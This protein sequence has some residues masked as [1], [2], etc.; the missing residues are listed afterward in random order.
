MSNGWTPEEEKKLIRKVDM[1]MVPILFVCATLSGLDKTAISGAAIYGLRQ[2]LGLSGSQY[3]W[4]GSAPFF[5]GLLFMG[6]AA[7]G[8]QY[9]PAIKFFAFNVLMWGVTAMCMAACTNFAGLFICRFL[10]GG[11]EALLIPAITLV[12]TM[13]YKPEE[14]PKRNAIILNV[15][16]PI[17]NGFISWTV[18]YHKGAFAGWKIIFLALGVFTFLWAFVVFFFLPN[19]PL[20]ATWLTGREKFIIIQR[21]AA[22]NTGVESKVFKKEQ[23]W[24][25][26]TDPKTWLIWF[27]IVALQVP[28]G[29]LTTFNTLIISGLGFDSLHTSL[30]AMP[31][32]AMSTLS[33]IGL[34]FL[35]ATTRKYRIALVTTSILLPLLGA[36]LCYAL[37]RD[38][39]A[40]QLVG[41]Y[42]LYTYWA[43]Y[44]TLVSIYQANTAGHTKKIVLFA[45]YFIAWAIGNIIGPQT[46]RQSQAPVYTGGTIAMIVC[47][48]VAISLILAY[49]YLCRR[50]NVRRAD[51]VAAVGDDDWLDM[52]DREI[53]GFKYTT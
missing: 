12:V 33:G 42:I 3:S 41:L 9:F 49:G 44:V 40:G 35:A 24:E 8:L 21:K 16:A 30:L 25:A 32:G 7:W 23:A 48:V 37:P 36:V 28:N 10:L 17:L 4:C 34:S 26:M 11:F 39:L 45:F 29:G 22:D 18:S 52:T 2:D 14:Q 31:P 13:W 43:P 51:E 46:F 1:R 50:D 5:G 19:N 38:N 27:A 15:I 53:K 47:Y 20:E 6:P